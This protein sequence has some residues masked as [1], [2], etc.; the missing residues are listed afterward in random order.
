MR[1]AGGPWR[2]GARQP[3]LPV[4]GRFYQSHLT[5]PGRMNVSGASLYGVPVDQH[6][7]HRE[8]RPEPHGVDC[9]PL[10][11]RPAPPARPRRPD[12]LHGR[13]RVGAD[14]PRPGHVQVRQPDGTIA[15]VT[16][17]YSTRY[18]PITTS[19]RVRT[20]SAGSTTARTVRDSP[21]AP[22]SST[23]TSRS[24]ATPAARSGSASPSC[25]PSAATGAGR[26]STAGS[27]WPSSRACWCRSAPST[28]STSTAADRRRSFT[29]STS[30]TAP[31]PSRTSPRPSRGRSSRPCS[32]SSG[33][34]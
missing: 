16:H 21:P 17:A 25:S 26:G 23:P 30:S 24:V 2:D 11:P 6:G 31:T 13:R 12:A 19:I 34:E 27:S 8:A 7:L 29:A 32:S 28:R 15:P 4:D 3:A 14:G 9:L 18:G 1:R 5:I 33:R 20:S 10:R 22:H